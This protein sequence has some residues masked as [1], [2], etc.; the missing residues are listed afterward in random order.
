[1]INANGH[2]DNSKTNKEEII[3]LNDLIFSPNHSE[4]VANGFVKIGKN[5][6]PQFKHKVCLIR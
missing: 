4:N 5:E 2:I 6:T 1:M 3:D